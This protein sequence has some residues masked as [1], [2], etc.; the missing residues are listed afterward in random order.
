MTTTEYI[1]TPTEVIE[2]WI[3]HDARW[4]HQARAAARI[5]PDALRRYVTGLVCDYRDGDILLTTDYDRRSLGAV[6]SDLADGGG[7]GRVCWDV[8]R[9]SLLVPDRHRAGR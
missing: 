2:A 9:E 3:P 8:V 5:G 7:I 4:H 1:P 6:S